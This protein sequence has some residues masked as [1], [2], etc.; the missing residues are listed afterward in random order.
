VSVD[1]DGWWMYYAGFDASGVF[2]AGLARA[3]P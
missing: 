3:A 2:S 1:A